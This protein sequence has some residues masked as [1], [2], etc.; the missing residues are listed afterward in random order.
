MGHLNLDSLPWTYISCGL[1]TPS[2][3]NTEIR[4]VVMV[5]NVFMQVLTPH[6]RSET[7]SLV[8]VVIVIVTTNITD[9]IPCRVDFLD[10]SLIL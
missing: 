2:N 6:T 5:R 3:V 7:E 1:W 10:A 9:D 4:R 8:F